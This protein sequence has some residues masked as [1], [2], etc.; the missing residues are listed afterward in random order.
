MFIVSMVC[1]ILAV[2]GSLILCAFSVHVL[3]RSIKESAGEAIIAQALFGVF[4]SYAFPV[5]FPFIVSG[6][7]GQDK[8]SSFMIIATTMSS[9]FVGVSW[10]KS[11]WSTIENVEENLEKKEFLEVENND[12]PYSPLRNS[13]YNLCIRAGLT[14][15]ELF[16]SNQKIINGF[17]KASRKTNS[18]ALTEGCLELTWPE[19]KAIVG[20]EIIHIKYKDNTFIAVIWRILGGIFLLAVL[21]FYILIIQLINN[22][23]PVVGVVITV[24]TLPFILLYEISMLIF[25]VIDNRRYWYQIQELRADRLACELPDI[26]LSGMLALLRSAA[27]R[28]SD[29]FNNLYWYKKV[30]YRYFLLLEHPSAKHRYKLI[31]KYRKWSFLEYGFHLFQITKWFFTGKGWNGF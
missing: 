11:W 23:L 4:L 8:G 19:I 5:V 10:T 25:L 17:A 9:F 26:E 14:N 24:V 2:T 29:W 7:L 16:L 13:I 31:R 22:F 6:F 18:I 21:I 3:A 30:Y 27:V 20:H 1:V 28:E 15:V 12:F